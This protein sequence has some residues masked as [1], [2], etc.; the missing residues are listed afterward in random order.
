[1][2]D[3]IQ[4]ACVS[5]RDSE[6]CNCESPYTTWFSQ[7]AWDCLS[8]IPNDVSNRHLTSLVPFHTTVVQN[9]GGSDS[10][11]AGV[12]YCVACCQHGPQLAALLRV[13]PLAPPPPISAANEHLPHMRLHHS[14]VTRLSNRLVYL[15]TR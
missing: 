15:L 12:S 6:P 8:Y 7:P 3:I 14:W 13:N 5:S 10:Q 4:R 1:M 9:Y 11:G 2:W